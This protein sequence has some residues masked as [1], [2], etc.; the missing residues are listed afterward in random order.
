MEVDMYRNEIATYEE[1]FHQAE[2]EIAQARRETNQWE[3]HAKRA[4]AKAAQWEKQMNVIEERRYTESI[5]AEGAVGILRSQI[6]VLQKEVLEQTQR[7]LK[8]KKKVCCFCQSG[9]AAI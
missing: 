8:Y 9:E 2:L 6:G 5:R 3:K 1:R 7:K 4:E